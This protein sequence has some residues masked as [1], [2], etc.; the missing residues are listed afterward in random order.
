MQFMEPETD[1]AL[2]YLGR[3]ASRRLSAEDLRSH[4]VRYLAAH[5]HVES[6]SPDTPQYRACLALRRQL[7]ELVW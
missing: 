3:L 2:R 7:A 5:F 1:R 6:F 4:W